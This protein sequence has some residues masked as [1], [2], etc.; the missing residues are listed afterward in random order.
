MTMWVGE[1]SPT[2]MNFSVVVMSTCGSAAPNKPAS[3]LLSSHWREKLQLLGLVFGLFK[4]FSEW[5]HKPH[6]KRCKNWVTYEFSPEN[7]S[8][9]PKPA[10]HRWWW[11]STQLSG[12]FTALHMNYLSEPQKKVLVY[13]HPFPPPSPEQRGR[14]TLTVKLWTFKPDD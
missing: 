9:R 14:R 3:E 2:A 6:W 4:L 10:V 8:H 13:F 7:K 11:C 1:D 12:Y 5:H